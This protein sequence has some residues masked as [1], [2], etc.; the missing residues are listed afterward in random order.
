[1][2]CIILYPHGLW[3]LPSAWCTHPGPSWL[4]GFVCFGLFG[5]HQAGL[6]CPERETAKYSSPPAFRLEDLHKL[7]PRAFSPRRTYSLSI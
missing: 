2:K 5:P 6:H 1:M 3:Y 4:H 7:F